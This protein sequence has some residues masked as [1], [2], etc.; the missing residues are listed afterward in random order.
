MLLQKKKK[1]V[2]YK[3]LKVYCRLEVCGSTCRTGCRY[4]YNEIV[5]SKLVAIIF[6]KQTCPNTH[7]RTIHKT[8]TE[9]QQQKHNAIFI[10]TTG[11]GG[12]DG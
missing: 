9:K 10:S 3:K 2:K 11:G 8:P 5:L 6:K 4:M 1:R 12:I 7:T